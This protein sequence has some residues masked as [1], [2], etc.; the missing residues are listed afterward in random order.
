MTKTRYA[1][2]FVL[3]AV[4]LLTCDG[5]VSGPS[6]ASKRTMNNFIATHRY[7]DAE[8]YLDTNKESQYG[9]KNSVLFYLDKGVVQQHA[10]QYKDSDASLGLAE[11]RMDELYT[12]SITKTGGMLL[13]NDNTVDYAGEPY[14]RALL[15]VFRALNYAFLGQPDEAIVE[16]RKLERFLQELNDTTGGKHV[17]KDDAFA[18]YVNSLLFADGG[19]MDDAR[20]SLQASENAYRDYVSDYGMPTPHFN[21]PG[22]ERDHG[23][24]VFVHYNGVAPRKVTK[25]WQ[26]AFNQA[27]L[28]V[29]QSSDAEAQNAQARNAI[30]AGFLGNAITVAY[31]D[32]VQDPYRIVASDVWVDSKP[33]ASTQL[34]EDVTAIAAHNLQNRIGLIKARAIARA[35]V[36]Y[37]LAEVAARAARQACDRQFSVASWQNLLCKATT[38]GIAHGVAAATEVADV[39]CWGTLPAQIRMA[40]VKLPAGKHDVAVLFKDA[41]GVVVSTQTFSGVDIA[42]AKR[43]YLAFRTAQ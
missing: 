20:I 30:A 8:T 36:K 23:E 31:P 37:V 29:Q 25:T 34:M 1:T 40:R 18:H 10:G 17:Y 32:F 9:K 38:S 28:I 35:T 11:Q 7:A 13:L 41:A 15:N 33:V 22:H 42:D 2:Y 27:A 26:I 19:K 43:T 4:G 16:S 6:G 39:R 24:L 5:C 14:E 21:M 3:I 12:K